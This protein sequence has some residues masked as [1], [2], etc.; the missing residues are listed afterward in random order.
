[1]PDCGPARATRSGPASNS[2]RRLGLIG[3]A[4]GGQPPIVLAQSQGPGRRLKETAASAQYP[5][6]AASAP[7]RGGL[8]RRRAPDPRH[9][10][11]GSSRMVQRGGRMRVAIGWD[12]YVDHGH[13]PIVVV[14][15]VAEI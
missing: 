2:R 1:M 12:I 4:Y 6:R 5:A 11:V 9:Y 15:Q 13:P 14:V 7:S 3:G 10:S 8:A